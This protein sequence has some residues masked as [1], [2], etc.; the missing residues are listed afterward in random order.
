MESPPRGPR[1]ALEAPN[2]LLEILQ[3]EDIARRISRREALQVPAVMRARNLI[4][5]TLATLPLRYHGPDRRA[6]PW[7]LFH[8]PDPDIPTSVVWAMTYE[9]LFFE[10]V[11]WWRVMAFGW[12]GYPV[13]ARHVPVEAVHVAGTPSLPS[14]AQITPDQPIPVDGQV[15]IDGIPVPDREIIR[16]DSP[17]PP[18]LI[19]AARAIRT[20]LKLDKA[21]DLY[22]DDPLPL[23]YFTPAEGADPL[24][25][26]PGSADDGTDRSEVDVVLDE[27]ELSRR[28]RAWGYVGALKAETL[29]WNPEQLQL[30]DQRQHAVL[31]IARAA[32]VDPEDLGVSTTSRTYQ[33]SEQRRQDLIDFTLGA[34]VSA[35][36]DRLSMR[37]VAQRGYKARIDFGGFLRGDTKTRMETYKVGLEVG[38]YTEDEI[39]ELEDRPPLTPAQRQARTARAD[40]RADDAPAG[41]TP[42]MSN[43]HGGEAREPAAMQ[44]FGADDSVRVAFDSDDVAETFQVDVEKRTITGLAVPWGKIAKSG[45]SKWRF[46]QDSLRWSDTSRVK[47]NLHHDFSQLIGR[48][49]RLQS[50]SKGLTATFKVARGAEGDRA[51]NL[52]ED[53]VLDG[54]SIEIDF[55]DDKG[56]SWQPDPSDESVRLVRQATLRGTAL[57]GMPAF[58]D[59][60]VTRVAATRNG[61]KG[62]MPDDNKPG[63]GGGQSVNLQ[64]GEFTKFMDG[65]AAQIADSHKQ[66][67]EQ[68][69][70]SIGE[71][72][73][74]GMKAALENIHDPQ[75]DG[76]E[77]VRAARFTVTREAPIYTFDG[78]GNSLVRDAW[79]AQREHDDEAKER[80]RRFHLQSA[81][82]QKLAQQY[83]SRQTAMQATQAQMGGGAQFATVTTGTA[84][85]VI[86]PGYRPDLFVPQLAQGRPLY[87]LLSRGTIA[88]ATPFVV[89][90]FGSL[91]GGTGDHAEGT[92]PTEGTLA[93]GSETVTPGAISGKLPLTREIVDSSNPAI[94]Q[95]ALAAMRES[96]AQ[97]TET[98][99]YAA[100]NGAAAAANTESISDAA[101]GD[102]S[103]TADL[104]ITQARDLLARYPFVRFA[105]PNGAAIGQKVTRNFANAQDST[106]RPLLPS[107][108]AQ[109]TAGLGNAVSMGWFVDGLPHVPAWAITEAIGDDIAFILNSMDAW[110]WESPVLAFRFEEKQGP[111][112]IELALFGYFATHVLRPSGVFALRL[113]A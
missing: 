75:R 65:M 102:G 60:R 48:A 61:G 104:T 108:G 112:I 71:S 68:L 95:I 69:G 64:A 26:D 23:G 29:Q 37:D 17:N 14:Q 42:A 10:G 106:G 21:A 20:C 49:T 91:T 76:P 41:R 44:T 66:L 6:V 85:E 110:A 56:D 90:T 100:L 107:V 5:G 30:A 36:Q 79:Y 50:G 99:V 63:D 62:A 16:F 34:W 113:A 51:L 73:A 22:S 25:S 82:V 55:D 1:F 32:G 24:S 46:A 101:L 70:A 77:P 58:D 45:F 59:A 78:R 109:N 9:D 2:D 86:P 8:Q 18:F 92:S 98:K 105:A 53:K 31:E 96:Y 52:A 87:N 111:E 97:Q 13:E 33:N 81:E 47:L 19:H 103:S 88:N 67:T 38:A 83:V 28:R 39:R 74:A 54:F 57:T 40:G 35:V 15:F 12:H 80:I 7:P 43:G 11:A 84:S 89:P 94:D 93:L 4:C 27:W 3:S 72:V